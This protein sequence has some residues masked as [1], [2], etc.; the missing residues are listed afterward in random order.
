MQTYKV[1]Y[2]LVAGRVAQ[3][4]VRAAFRL[5]TPLV[6]GVDTRLRL[7][8][9]NQR[10]CVDTKIARVGLLARQRGSRVS[11]VRGLARQ[12]R[13]RPGRRG[14]R[15]R[16]WGWLPVAR[17]EHREIGEHRRRDGLGDREHE[18]GAA[19]RGDVPVEQDDA[20]DSDRLPS[21]PLIILG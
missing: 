13:Y 6:A 1:K 18:S 17:R 3:G 21:S 4:E 5:R 10:I 16:W 12:R 20:L 2:S 8:T 15:R 9:A 14:R 7:P 19:I 11:F